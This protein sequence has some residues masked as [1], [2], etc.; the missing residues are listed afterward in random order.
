MSPLV[1]SIIKASEGFSEG[2]YK[3]LVITNNSSTPDSQIDVTADVAVLSS[4][5][6]PSKNITFRN[7]SITIDID[8]VAAD[9]TSG[10]DTGTESNDTMYALWLA[11]K[12]DSSTL[13]GIISENFSAPTTPTDY[14]YTLL[15]GSVR[16]GS[17]DTNI[18][19]QGQGDF[20]RIWQVNNYVQC[21]DSHIILPSTELSTSNWTAIDLSNVLGG[22]EE[23][24]PL[25]ICDL[26]EITA[27]M[28]HDTNGT[29]LFFSG[30]PNRVNA[31]GGIF[32]GEVLAGS[33]LSICKT[34][35]PITASN[36]YYRAGAIVATA[37]DITLYVT[38]Y[39]ITI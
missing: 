32:A 39:I 23:I 26:V 12:S 5:D 16:N 15:V 33:T 8:E 29:T 24:V 27:Y 13:I 17:S 19:P 37:P 4:T 2:Y 7:V 1:G 11:G 21:N 14:D 36:I 20:S 38:A 22:A 10:L 30:D 6:T 31:A 25:S 18:D 35:V 28:Q 9:G 3:N 34:F